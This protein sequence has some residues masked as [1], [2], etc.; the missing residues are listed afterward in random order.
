MADNFFEKSILKK[1]DEFINIVIELS[2]AKDNNSYIRE[3]ALQ[4]GTEIIPLI[5]HFLEG[6]VEHVEA[7]FQQLVMQ[8]L[9]E[10]RIISSF[11]SFEENLHSFIKEVVETFFQNPAK[12]VK[13]SANNALSQEVKNPDLEEETIDDSLNDFQNSIK[14]V[15]PN[16][17]ILYDFNLRGE[18]V[19]AYIPEFK[20]A[21]VE[22]NKNKNY[23]KLKYLCQ[24]RGLNLIELPSEISRNYRRLLRYLKSI[25]KYK[26]DF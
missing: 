1:I 19:D 25:N 12:V 3:Q 11:G 10:P 8:R 13:E 20:L 9:P 17:E 7:M 16:V 23:A 4:K 22:K 2:S 24:T 21:I 15:F 18:K 14:K 5:L 26:K 6:N